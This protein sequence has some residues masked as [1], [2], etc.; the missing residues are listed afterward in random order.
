MS[1]GEVERRLGRLLTVPPSRP[2]L[3]AH[4]ESGHLDGRKNRVNGYYTV[5]ESALQQYI[6]LL[7]PEAVAA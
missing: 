7:I 4:I 3:I 5:R 6:E 2:T 1:L